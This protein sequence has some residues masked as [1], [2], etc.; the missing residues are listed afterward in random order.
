MVGHRNIAEYGSSMRIFGIIKCVVHTRVFANSQTNNL[1]TFHGIHNNVELADTRL[2]IN[3][4]EGSS[5]DRTR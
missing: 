4:R 5:T 1:K 2:E 3:R